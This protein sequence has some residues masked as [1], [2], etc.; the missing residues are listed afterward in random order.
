MYNQLTS[1][2]TTILM[3]CTKSESGPIPAA[4]VMASNSSKGSGIRLTGCRHIV[5][6]WSPKSDPT[7]FSSSRISSAVGPSSL[8][9]PTAADSVMVKNRR[10]A[11]K[12]FFNIVD[13]G[14]KYI[15][16]SHKSLNRKMVYIFVFIL[17]MN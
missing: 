15:Y 1:L 9:E 17:I 8:P 10:V 11:K 14:E 4:D 16:Q 13:R 3:V 12:I 2:E 7:P 5:H 6:T